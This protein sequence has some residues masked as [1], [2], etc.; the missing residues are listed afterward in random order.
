MNGC[1]HETLKV[2][3]V[4]LDITLFDEK[5][6]LFKRCDLVSLKDMGLLP[7][8]TSDSSNNETLLALQ[9][10]QIADL[11]DFVIDSAAIKK[12]RP[13]PEIYFRCCLNFG[14]SPKEVAVVDAESDSTFLEAAIKSGCQ[15]VSAVNSFSQIMT[16]LHQINQRLE[17]EP[18]VTGWL[19]STQVVVSLIDE[20]DEFLNDG[21][22]YPGM[23]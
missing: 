5:P 4:V 18:I 6:G 1:Q 23:S 8:C 20:E 13:C 14:L 15:Y 19:Q 9:S 12:K 17:S 22:G 11:F 7:S 16:A 21:Y 10:K 3:L 2:K